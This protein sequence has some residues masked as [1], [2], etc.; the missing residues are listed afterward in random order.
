MATLVAAQAKSGITP[1]AI[2][3]G[4]NSV[5]A[6]YSLTATLADAD[7]VQ[8]CKLPDGARITGFTFQTT[9]ALGTAAELNLGTRSNHDLLV[10][11]ATCAAAQ[12]I[13]PDSGFAAV[14]GIGTQLD[15]SD[16]AT[17]K[18]TMVEV[19]VSGAAGATNTGSIAVTID[20]QLDQ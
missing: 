17:T 9:P 3:A 13:G 8:M 14:G 16:A 18:Y 2:H 15:V 11:S 10:A 1:R 12:V 5:Y 7:V 6:V 20:Y 4:V 19:T